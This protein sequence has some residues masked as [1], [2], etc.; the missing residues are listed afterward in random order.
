M[1]NKGKGK[2][3]QQGGN[4]RGNLTS[5]KAST[6][7]Y[8]DKWAGTTGRDQDTQAEGGWGDEDTGHS[9][10]PRQAAQHS[11]NNNN[12]TAGSSNPRQYPNA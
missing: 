11:G 3:K 4:E 6:Y 5:Y 12:G 8:H 7:P 10:Q 9:G 1:G 2:E